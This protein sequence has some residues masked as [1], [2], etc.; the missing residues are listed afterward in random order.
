MN[1]LLCTL[2]ASWAVIPE[3]LGWIA[4]N[5]LDLYAHHPP[6]SMLDE[7]RERHQLQ[8]SGKLWICT[9]QGEQTQKS[10]E[11]LQCWWENI[12]MPLPLRIWTAAARRGAGLETERR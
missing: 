10:L 1:I 2:G 12:G 7:L 8:P 4:P 3:I 5:L 6:R 11:Q 9:T